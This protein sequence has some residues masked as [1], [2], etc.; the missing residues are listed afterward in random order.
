MSKGEIWFHSWVHWFPCPKH[1]LLMC[2]MAP[3]RPHVM[4]QRSISKHVLSINCIPETCLAVWGLKGGNRA[5]EEYLASPSCLVSL[6]PP[7]TGWH[8]IPRLFGPWQGASRGFPGGTSGKKEK[9]QNRNVICRSEGRSVTEGKKQGRG[10]GIQMY[11]TGQGNL[12]EEVTGEH[13]PPRREEGPILQVRED[14]S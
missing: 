12:A 5:C 11:L 1:S 3:L 13:Q 9:K 4:F 14:N 10:T 2:P 7:E 8:K 6:H